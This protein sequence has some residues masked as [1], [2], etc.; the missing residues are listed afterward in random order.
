MIALDMHQ[1]YIHFSA[2][3]MAKYSKTSQCLEMK[4]DQRSQLKFRNLSRSACKDHL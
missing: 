4:R 2:G 3:I 1:E